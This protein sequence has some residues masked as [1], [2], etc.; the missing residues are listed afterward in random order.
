[1]ATL[2]SRSP[3]ELK[4][5]ACFVRC[6]PLERTGSPVNT[7]TA[8]FPRIPRA[9]RRELPSLAQVKLKRT[10]FAHFQMPSS[11]KAISSL[12]I[13]TQQNHGDIL[14]LWETQRRPLRSPRPKRPSKRSWSPFSQSLR[15]FNPSIADPKLK[16][17]NRC[18][19]HPPLY[20]LTSW[21]LRFSEF[22]FLCL[23]FFF[24]CPIRLTF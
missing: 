16:I 1:V 15:A 22:L 7:S 2:R 12:T 6:L 8:L 13:S 21:L 9:P 17:L 3:G 19:N 5:K 10:C 23:T 18:L 14:F 11:S 24:L 20:S 4:T